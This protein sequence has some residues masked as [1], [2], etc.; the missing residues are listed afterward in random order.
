MGALV[1]PPPHP[2]STPLF[3]YLYRWTPPKHLNEAYPRQLNVNIDIFFSLLGGSL[4]DFTFL[5]FNNQRCAVTNCVMP[6]HTIDILFPL[7]C[8]L[9]S[10][11]L[12][13]FII[14]LFLDNHRCPVIDGI[15]II[16]ILN[17]N[18]TQ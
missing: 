14:L 11:T 16:W 1:S 17:W 4:R 13:H 12:R 15:I 5:F 3:H 8:Y 6:S 7:L 2:T 18:Q 10:F 9:E